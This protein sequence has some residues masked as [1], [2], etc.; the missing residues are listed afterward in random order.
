MDKEVEN[1]KKI[2][3]YGKNIVILLDF[4]FSLK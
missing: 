4:R 1:K 2:R 3:K